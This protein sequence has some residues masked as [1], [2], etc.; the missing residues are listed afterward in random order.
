MQQ[1]SLY[2]APIL[3]LTPHRN[4]TLID[5]H[6]L[7]QNNELL[8]GM[9]ELYRSGDIPACNK[10][11]FKKEA[12]E[13]ITVSG[14][15]SKRADLNLI[16]YSNYICIDCD[17]LTA[18]EHLNLEDFA[19]NDRHVVFA[20]TSPSGGYKIF[21]L[22]SSIDLHEKIFGAFRNYTSQTTGIELDKFDRSCK[23]ISRACFICHDPNAYINPLIVNGR[24]K[25]IP[26]IDFEKYKIDD[27]IKP[28][29]D[30]NP[31]KFEKIDD[32]GIKSISLDFSNR[33]LELNFKLLIGM[34][35]QKRG[36]YASPREPWIQ[37]LASYCNQFGM[38]CEKALE[39][40]LKYFSGHPESIRP[41]KPIDI[42]K[43]LVDPVR[44][45]Y[46]RYSDQFCTW[47]KDESTED[48]ETPSL[49]NSVYENLP[50]FLKSVLLLYK[51]DRERD[52]VFL[53]T[54][55]VLS[56]CFPN[57]YGI[58][59]SKRVAANLFFFIVAPAS[60]GK[61]AALATRNIGNAVQNKFDEEYSEKIRE[62]Q[63]ALSE[64]KRR[65]KDEEETMEPEKPVR[66]ILFI[67][68]NITSPKL[69]ETL[70]RNKRVGIIMDS[71]ADTLTQSLKT[72]HGNFSDIIRKTFHH[73]PIE[74][75]RKLNDEYTSLTRSYLSLVLTGTPS[76]VNNL[77]HNIENGFFSRF[78]FYNFPLKREWKNVF[79]KAKELPEDLFTAM[80]H[81]LA[82]FIERLKLLDEIDNVDESEKINFVLSA[83]QE[84]LF[85]DWFDKKEEQLFNLYGSDII[86]S[87][88]RM[89]LIAFRIA[90]ILALIRQ[91][92]AEVIGAT[93]LCN[94][95][96]FK[97]SM[98]IVDCL[99]FHTMKVFNQLKSV[100]S[101]NAK[102]I[103]IYFEKLPAEFTWTNAKE[104]AA[105]LN[106]KSKTA[107]NYIAKY[108][109][110]K[111]LER[112]E[113]GNYRK[114]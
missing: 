57:Y 113:H 8:K 25:E 49:P 74:L 58:Y 64:H 1:F 94:D 60:S 54:L 16:A 83:S 66:K 111:V 21:I 47:E 13:Y 80:S 23:N 104:I 4:I 27:L 79:E 69:I 102:P 38:S 10:A 68:A 15:F 22:C 76:Q 34:V 93:I 65:L 90:M 107:E 44:D 6:D 56:T 55:G 82:D 109:S 108:I 18:Q 62:Y 88:R 63:I 106:I 46:K 71:E 112:V 105:L 98:D 24:E 103:T 91:M 3:N 30:I 99:L 29:S 48:F 5:L 85:N 86:P 12:F 20:F 89:G 87:V 26:I 37:V 51:N 84:Q 52:I 11:A 14:I 97:A 31:K 17:N 78:I 39:L 72:Q 2:N 73:E 43:Y 67:P 42:Q 70:S 114:I 28:N 53:S 96:D 9:T 35:E 81:K 95:H 45:A 32:Y 33:E 61:G 50:K 19:R 77:L 36:Q 92:D 101:K 75:Q 59:S 110:Q 41:D 7:I 100:K 40:T